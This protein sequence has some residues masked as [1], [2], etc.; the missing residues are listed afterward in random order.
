VGG[1]A[2]YG[3]VPDHAVV[4]PDSKLSMNSSDGS[5]QFFMVCSLGESLRSV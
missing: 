5:G 3:T 4:S 2:R 1:V